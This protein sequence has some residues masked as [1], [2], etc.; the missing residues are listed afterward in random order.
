[1]KRARWPKTHGGSGAVCAV[2]LRAVAIKAAQRR[3]DKKFQRFLD[4]ARNDN[5]GMFSHELVETDVAPE[6]WGKGGAIGFSAL[7]WR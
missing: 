7:F 3:L 2:P 5:Y 1:M 6:P 4:C